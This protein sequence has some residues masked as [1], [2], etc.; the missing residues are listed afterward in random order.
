M[1]PGAAV[2]AGSATAPR[3]HSAAPAVVAVHA[4]FHRPDQRNP[5]TGRVD[6]ESTEMAVPAE[7]AIRDCYRANA[8]ARRTGE[9]G[10]IVDIVNNYASIG[11]DASPSLVDWL[12]DVAPWTRRRMIEADAETVARTG[13]G[14]AFAHPY[15]HA[16]LP[17]ASPADR[18]TLVRWGIGHFRRTF[19]RPPDGMWLP[20]TAVDEATLGTLADEG[21]GQTILTAGQVDAVRPLPAGPWSAPAGPDLRRAHRYVLGDG[22]SVMCWFQDPLYSVAIA[23][24]NALLDGW[25]LGTQIAADVAPGEV[26][27][28]VADGETFGLHHQRGDMALA[29]LVA[30]LDASPRVSCRPYASLGQ[31]CRD[32][33]EVRLHQPSARS[34]Q[35]G[36]ERWRS[37]CGDT[38]AGNPTWNQ[39][40]RRPLRHALDW[41]AEQAGDMLDS[42]GRELFDDPWVARDTYVDVLI[43]PRAST[44]QRFLRANGVRP[45]AGVR[46]LSMLELQRHALTALDSGAWSG[47]DPAEPATVLAL[48]HADRAIQLAGAAFEIDLASSLRAR[49][50]PLRGNRIDLATAD[51]L[52]DHLVSGARTD[53]A[54]IARAEALR[55]MVGAAGIAN[56][57]WQVRAM[58]ARRSTRGARRSCAARYVVTD[59]TTGARESHV[60]VVLNDGTGRLQ[61]AALG[62]TTGDLAD[63]AVRA[64]R[65]GLAGVGAASL[66]DLSDLP[67]ADRSDVLARHVEAVAAHGLGNL[68]VEPGMALISDLTE[69]GADVPPALAH[70]VAGALA[71]RFRA[72][73]DQSEIDEPAA[74]GLLSGGTAL[75]WASDRQL[76]SAIE[77]AL[78]RTVRWLGQSL[79][80]PEHLRRLAVLARLSARSSAPAPSIWWVQN[81]VVGWLRALSPSAPAATRAALG[82]LAAA[83]DVAWPGSGTV[84]TSP[85]GRDDSWAGHEN[86][87]VHDGASQT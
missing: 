72:L 31:G 32:L 19:G 38:V 75:A 37:D 29:A 36:V 47:A 48:R 2:P 7:L 84:D 51:E 35:H 4:H 3:Q 82:E 49:L 26:L 54:A 44:R 61:G 12:A 9:A 45:S 13:H 65:R 87:G 42:L 55:R 46:A 1:K 56:H 40:W 73:L 23:F 8:A 16:I 30:A 53:A 81:A 41:L 69:L 62:P 10:D 85:A 39:R 57:R 66:F 80:P 11:W 21:I 60:L 27:G 25:S 18:R 70:A 28:L 74:I 20:E 17:L 79:P 43:D 77:A 24:G 59:R 67:P 68:G 76:A 5:W 33:P 78:A 50:A 64:C 86:E 71:N 6:I 14:V 63:V 15:V 58:G 22:R 52:W 83:T 34:C